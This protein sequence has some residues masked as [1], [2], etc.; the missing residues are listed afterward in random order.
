MARVLVVDDH[1][2][3]RGVLRDAVVE[4]G[5]EVVGE[6]ADGDTALRMAGGLRP[7]LVLM[8]LS[9]P[10]SDGLS[11][12]RRMRRQAPDTLVLI[13]TMHA[14]PDLLDRAREAGAVGY[15]LK[16]S[17][18]DQLVAAIGVVLGGGTAFDRELVPPALPAAT[19]GSDL[20]PRELQVL[21]L[22]C[23]GASPRGVADA[24][25]IAAKTVDNHLT[26]IYG[27][28]GVHSRSEA[29][30]EALRRGLVPTPT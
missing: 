1:S 24:L 23:D 19:T 3:V 13:V 20:T 11:A 8:D 12:T 26:S 29:V 10:G 25:V 27:K 7:A 6:A 9:M 15:V 2:L 14:E 17:S 5:H 30:T 21:G 28:L 4:A 18:R 22:V 16:D